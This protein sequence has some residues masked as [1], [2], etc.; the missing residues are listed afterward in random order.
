M[1]PWSFSEEAA[2]EKHMAQVQHNMWVTNSRAAALF[3]A[4]S[5]IMPH[6]SAR[7]RMM[8][9]FVALSSTM[10]NRLPASCVCGLCQ[11][12]GV[13]VDGDFTRVLERYLGE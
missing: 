8:R 10:S 3:G 11:L 4:L 1:L 6:C 9:L 7:F 12:G 13:V 2:A 5:T